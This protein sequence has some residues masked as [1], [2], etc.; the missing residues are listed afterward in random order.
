MA[1]PV[2]LF[3]TAE[4]EIT[5]EVP[6][7]SA[8]ELILLVDYAADGCPLWGAGLG[9]MLGPLVLT[10]LVTGGFIAAGGLLYGWLMGRVPMLPLSDP[11]LLESLKDTEERD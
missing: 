8:R 10:F 3:I 4:G 2:L 1:E 5:A 11:L 9:A 6:L 7:P